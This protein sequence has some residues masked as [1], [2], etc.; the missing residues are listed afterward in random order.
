[1]L[2]VLDGRSAEVSIVRWNLKE[3]GV[4]GTETIIIPDI[5]FMVFPRRSVNEDTINTGA[6]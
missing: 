3:A 5:L 2:R 6:L 1:M 4:G